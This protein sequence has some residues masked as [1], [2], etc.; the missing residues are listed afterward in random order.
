MGTAFLFQW[1]HIESDSEAC[2]VKLAVE[3]SGP[4]I[5]VLL[6]GNLAGGGVEK[7]WQSR[8]ATTRTH[9]DRLIPK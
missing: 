9:L 5:L 4:A 6:F 2:L 7:I 1:R 8:F 3:I